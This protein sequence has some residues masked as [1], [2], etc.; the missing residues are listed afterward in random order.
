MHNGKYIHI[1]GIDGSGKS[2]LINAARNWFAE[3]HMIVFDTIAWSQQHG[4]PPTY[5]DVK[6]ADVLFTAEPTHAWVG[7]A[8]R[9]EIIKTGSPHDARFTAQAYALDRAVQITRFVR[10]FLASKHHWVIQDRSVISSVAYQS[11]QSERDQDANPATIDWLVALQGNQIAIDLAPNIFIL[12]DIDAKV[13]QER[14]N[15]RTDKQDNARFENIDFQLALSERYRKPEVTQ[16]LRDKGT[17]ILTIDGSLTR[18]EVA[19]EMKK[20]LEQLAAQ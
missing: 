10:P 7:K 1:D 6:D 2:T 18:S 12:L 20:V 8:I 9:D 11:L 5:E 16:P 13:A 14:L 17:K 3:R 19:G 15:G 4:H